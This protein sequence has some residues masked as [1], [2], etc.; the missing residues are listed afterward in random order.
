M[1]YKKKLIEVALPLEAINL[2]SSREKSIRH[3]HPSTLHLWWARRPLAAARAIIFAQMVDDPSEHPDIFR[4]EKSQD[5][6][7]QRLFRIIEELVK[8]ES[9][10]NETVLNKA[11]D[12][13]LQSWRYTCAENAGNPRAN[14]LFDRY[15]LP[16]FHDPFSGGG[17]I[18]LEAQRLGLS[19]FASDLNP[20]PVLLNKAMLEIPSKF[21]NLAPVNPASKISQSFSGSWTAA[22]GLAEDVRYYADWMRNQA[23]IR[24]GNFYPELTIDEK[25]I[26]KQPELTN[27]NGKKLTV[28]A[29]IW[30]RTISTPNPAL[31]N[32]H[33]PLSSTFLLATRKG[34]EAFVQPV[35]ENGNYYFNVV[36][37]S[38]PD[39]EIVKNGTK[40]GRGA[41]FKCLVSGVPITS[42]YVKDE[43]K[44]GRLG[45]KLLAIVCEGDRG[46]IYISPNQEIEQLALSAKPSWTPDTP[47]PNDMRSH[48]TP[49]YGLDTYGSLFTKRQLLALNTFS[50]LVS[51]VRDVIKKDAILSGWKDDGLA[52]EGSSTGATAYSDAVAVYLGLA[53][54]RSSSMWSSNCWWQASGEFIAQVFTRQGIPM[55]WDFGE[56]NPFSN[57]TGNWTS[58]V[59]WIYK[60]MIGLPAKPASYAIQQDAATQTI[61]QDKVISTDPPY[62]DNIGYADLSDF[63]YVWH[64]RSMKTIF[65]SLYTTLAVPKEEEL[66]ATPYRHGGKENAEQFFLKGMTKAMSKISEQAHPAFPVTIYYAFKQT[67]ESADEGSSNTGWDTFLEAVIAAGFSISGTWPIRTERPSGVK[68][69]VNALASSIVLVCRKKSIT[70]SIV[71]RRT[72]ISALREELPSALAHL[73]AGNIAPVDLAQAAIGP[74]MAVYTRFEKVI[75]SEGRN[76]SVHS[77]LS[78][79]NQILDETLTKQDGDFDA[80]TRWSLTWFE[81]VGF[82][83]GDYGVAEQ[84]SKSKNTVITALVNEGIVLSKFGKVR[85]LKPIELTHKLEDHLDTNMTI[86]EAV[87]QLIRVL[88]SNGEGAAA[89]LAAKLGS[90]ADVARELC[91]RLF[92]LCERKKRAVE[93]MA[94]NGLV[95][96]WPE[97]VRLGS[98]MPTESKTGTNDLF[99]QE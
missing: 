31:N 6:E 24:I 46:R 11:R 74:G 63:Y 98:Q 19:S 36:N 60:V 34:R 85:L 39:N 66:V 84:L 69:S 27:Y 99:A 2:A 37:G 22:Q 82:A 90:K 43:G 40:L 97:I 79:I 42:Q 67:E 70:A 29:W 5:K 32:I 17:A 52:L 68:A 58:A 57:A 41:N 91:Y 55:V 96:S 8:W 76:I 61:S 20:I 64:R 35:V 28:I 75:D 50:D 51:E 44:A 92:T 72:F 53:I 54:G 13:I 23:F 73:Q 16:N 48:W 81:Q 93:A 95:Q 12:E 65:P 56:V 25:F 59:D 3:G 71:D 30:T 78:L 47:L 49:P 21:S 9:T 94:Y 1:I 77:A 83:E 7:R 45:I 62:Y 33:V 26:S 15:K 10:T 14:E 89:V 4:T 18:P 80:A 38:P 86:W 87:H 88:E